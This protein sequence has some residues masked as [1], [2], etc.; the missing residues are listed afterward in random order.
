MIE[1][2][3]KSTQEADLDAFRKFVDATR[4]RFAKTYVESYPHE[5]MLEQW[6]DADL[7]SRAIRSIE[8]WG[9]VNARSENPAERPTL[10]NRLDPD[11]PGR[12]WLMI[13]PVADQVLWNASCPVLT[14]IRPRSS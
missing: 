10:I 8:Q 9:L 2:E 6:V 13:G 14:A 7:F 5:Y 11:R 4:W 12:G 1:C 3:A